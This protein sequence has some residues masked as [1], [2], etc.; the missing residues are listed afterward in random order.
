M[1]KLYYLF[2][3][4]F[5][6]ITLS[7]QAQVVFQN[8]DFKNFDYN[9]KQVDEFILRFNLK[10]L[11]IQPNQSDQYERDNR[12]L[13]FD[14]KYY[15]DNSE[16][17][18]ELL[19]AVENQQTTLSFYDSTWFAIADCNVTY[20][21]K[22]NKLTLILRTEQVKDDIYKWSIID[23]KGTMLELTPKTQSEKLRLLPTDN[24]VN[25]IALQSITTTNAHNITLYD[26]KTHIND[27]LSV[28]NCLVYNKLLKVDNV[29]E[30]SY[31]F[32]QVKGYKFFV[33]NFTR[34]AKNAGWLIYD[35]QK[36][37]IQDQNEIASYDL[38]AP[39]E[40]ITQFYL[41]ISEYAK[42][43]SDV[44]NARTIQSLFYNT[45]KKYYFFGA[46]QIFDDID[47]YLH[48]Y[49]APYAYVTISDYLN[50]IEKISKCDMTL[51][52]SISD[53][54]TIQST[55]ISAIVTYKISA[56]NKNVILFEYYAKAT[57]QDGLIVDIV[58]F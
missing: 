33:K 48:K 19:S 39:E 25:F 41:A 28:F 46:K 44:A 30:L 23:A 1:R 16:I 27:R 55:Q 32:T 54:K 15:L 51:N 42:N 29:Q 36:D 53:V 20:L 40:L 4:I 5:S 49:S 21:G 35:V 38:A 34:E 3:I 11:L 2:V 10:E 22:K 45:P 58:P 6:L 12:T 56:E 52:Y 31:C 7:A 8:N 17:S 47:V 9:V 18:N 24:E 57:I 43:P 26:T 14:K 50:S 13:L 37:N